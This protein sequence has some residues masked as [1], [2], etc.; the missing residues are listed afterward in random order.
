MAENGLPRRGRAA[1]RRPGHRCGSGV[2]NHR[3]RPPLL[4]RLFW[5]SYRDG[6]LPF[7][8]S[9]E[10]RRVSAPM[11]RIVST[12]LATVT[13]LLLTVSGGATAAAASTGVSEA[14][15]IG[16]AA[17]DPGPHRDPFVRR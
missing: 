7:I 1:G 8:D 16:V 17:T 10:R 5:R 15:G 2:V 12:M 11:H 6:A 3:V 14:G 9:C 4:T 13:G